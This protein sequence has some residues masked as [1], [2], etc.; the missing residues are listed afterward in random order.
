M[1]E[2]GDEAGKAGILGVILLKIYPHVRG[3]SQLK[4]VLFKG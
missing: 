2:V 4:P 3:P 1:E